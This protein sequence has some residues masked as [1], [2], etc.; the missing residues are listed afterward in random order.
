VI[1]HVLLEGQ[2]HGGIMQGFGQ[3]FTEHC[4]YDPVSAQLL[5]GTFTDY[6]MPRADSLGEARLY[7]RSVPSP[8]NALGAKGVGEAG[9]TGAVPTLAHA[10]LDA[11]HPLGIEQLDFPYTPAKLWQAIDSAKNGRGMGE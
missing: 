2:L 3:V 10:V 9:T 4:V 6:T 1:N 11:L 5:T 7:D 8:T